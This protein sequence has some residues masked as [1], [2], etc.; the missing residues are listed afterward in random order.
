ML[1]TV[2]DS[3]SA[4]SANR[5]QSSSGSTTCTRG[6]LGLPLDEVCRVGKAARMPRVRKKCTEISLGSIQK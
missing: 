5:S 6:D 3:R 1:L 2:R 4:S